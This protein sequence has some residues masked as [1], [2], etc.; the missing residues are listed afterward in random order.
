MRFRKHIALFISL[1]TLV[2]GSALG[3]PVSD[4]MRQA[5]RKL[6]FEGA[7]LQ[8]EGRFA[9]ALDRFSR[10][11]RLV[12]A[13]THLVRMAQCQAMLHKLVEAAETYRQVMNSRL[14]DNA[15]PAFV[16]AQQQ[17]AAELPQV[18]ARIPTVKVDVSPSQVKDLQLS[19]NGQAVDTALVGVARPI[20]PGTHTIA[21]V[22]P[23]Y[24][25]AE[26]TVALKE[27]ES[28]VVP[29]VLQ[30]G[31]APAPV[32]VPVVPA[33][34]PPPAQPAPAAAPVPAE[35]KPAESKPRG[36][37][38]GLLLGVRIG[39]SIPTGKLQK[40]IAFA[41]R[42]KGGIA[43]GPEVAFR[44]ERMFLVQAIYEH[45][46]YGQGD[47]VSGFGTSNQTVTT[48]QYGHYVGG[49]LGILTNPEGT[50]F[51]GEAGVGYRLF[52][53]SLN[54]TGGGVAG[55][56]VKETYEGGQFT[57]GA[58]LGIKAGPVRLIPKVSVA[59]GAFTKVT[60]QGPST[61]TAAVD[62]AGHAIW[63]VGLSGAY[64]ID[65]KP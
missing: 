57:L 35:Y 18:E 37:S 30:P 46:R 29:I 62:D 56:Q 34:P 47:A 50:G 14:P 26:Q 31:G 13:P 22:A 55:T 19:F 33:N 43:F 7:K 49:H 53:Q 51:F 2:G 54:V 9:D 42:A 5:A 17:A 6:Y 12:Q 21:V 60:V 32:V 4:E 48:E 16:Q 24:N 52:T 38:S 25:R 28:R 1:V 23:G 11:Q 64:N 44:F 15:P 27:G 41:D 63:M 40:N 58:G 59:L 36:P 8:D 20:N 45:A 65:F 39:G 61:Q 10:A 3:Q